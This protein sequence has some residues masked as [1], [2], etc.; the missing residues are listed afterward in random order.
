VYIVGGSQYTV[1][2]AA[3]ATNKLLNCYDVFMTLDNGGTPMNDANSRRSVLYQ[4]TDFWP[5]LWRRPRRW[6]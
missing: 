6:A 2:R 5:A 4:D 1:H 3:Q